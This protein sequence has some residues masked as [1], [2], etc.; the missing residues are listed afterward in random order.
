MKFTGQVRIPDID[1][2][3]VP[4]TF[5][6]EGVQAEVILEGGEPLGRWSLFDVQARRLISAAF[7]VELDG[8]ELTF[9]ADEPIDFAYRGVEKMAEVWARFKSMNIVRRSFSVSR[10]RRGVLASRVPELRAAMEENLGI[11]PARGLAGAV[12]TPAEPTTDVVEERVERPSSEEPVETLKDD[13]TIPLVSDQPP[14][15]E[16]SQTSEEAERL[17]A[18]RKAI[19]EER[20]LLEEQRRALEQVQAD[21]EKREADRVKAFRLEMSRIEEERFEYERLEKE[22]QASMRAAMERLEAERGEIQK[23]S[24]EQ[25]QREK[26]DFARAAA[27]RKKMAELESERVRREREE[28]ERVAAAQREMERIEEQ[29]RKIESLERIKDQE[30]ASVTEPEPVAAEPEEVA[31][32]PE[33][34]ERP[35][36]KH[37]APAPGADDEAAGEEPT[38]A[39][40]VS[41]EPVPASTNGGR[42]VVDLGELESEPPDDD[43]PQTDGAPREK[44]AGEPESEPAMA[45][46]SRQGGIMGAVRAAFGRGAREHTHDFVDA[47]GGIGIAR[48]I[49]RECGYV[50]ITTED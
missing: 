48:S 3:G 21:A 4:A 26:E 8:E 25:E 31:A 44:P 49:C 36:A 29:K 42:T 33:R 45:G 40:P 14:I 41:E 19:E 20:A 28:S 6:I 10:S 7:Q 22:R 16:P 23:K 43:T 12:A 2:P 11:Q 13:H 27:L 39:T 34:A 15:A 9:I 38:G 46:A 50:S 37:A 30:V 18:E 32:E 5:V 24:A 35:A 47:P 1:H 17:A